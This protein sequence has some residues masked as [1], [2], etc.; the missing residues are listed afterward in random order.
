MH[1]L[2]LS[3]FFFP[4]RL[5]IDFPSAEPI[6]IHIGLK[7]IIPSRAAKSPFANSRESDQTL[8]MRDQSLGVAWILLLPSMQAAKIRHLRS[9]SASR[10]YRILVLRLHSIRRS[11][12]ICLLYHSRCM[13][14]GNADK[15]LRQWWSGFVLLFCALLFFGSG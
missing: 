2:D 14:R 8:H 13:L 6:A 10:A 4:P 15:S 5:Q 3:R 11:T 12:R 7:C 9:G 1:S